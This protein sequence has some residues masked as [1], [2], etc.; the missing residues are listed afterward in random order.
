ML[1]GEPSISGKGSPVSTAGA[2]CPVKCGGR[3]LRCLT[4]SLDSGGCMLLPA[5]CNLA[6]ITLDRGAVVTSLIFGGAEMSPC[7][8]PCVSAVSPR[9][10]QFPSPVRGGGEVG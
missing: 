9:V 3:S 5:A 2:P 8:A 7:P 6:G 4:A 1:K 10:A